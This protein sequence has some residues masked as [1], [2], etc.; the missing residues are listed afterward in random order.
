MDGDD[1]RTSADLDDRL[2]EFEIGRFIRARRLERGVTL[3]VVAKSCNYS[4]SYLSQV[5]RGIANPTLS[6]IKLIGQALGFTIGDILNGKASHDPIDEAG[7]AEKAPGYSILRKGQ[8]K[9]IR[10]PGSDISNDLLSPD[11][12]RNLEVIW[13]EAP[14]NT[15]SGGHPHIHEGEECGVVLSGCMRFWVGD[16]VSD[17]HAGDSIYLSSVLPHRWESAGPDP[18]T[19][20]WIISPPTF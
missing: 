7:T 5:E 18:L 12:R 10:Y 15:G 13:V 16:V 17:L 2:P 20:I 11:L 19:A 6:S 1:A 4:V 14:P 9:R 8:R 3:K